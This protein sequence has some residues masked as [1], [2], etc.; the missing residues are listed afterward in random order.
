MADA[1][2]ANTPDWR[3]ADIGTANGHGNA[4][5][6]ARVMSVLVG[7]ERSSG[8]GTAIFGAVRG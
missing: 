1:A 5:S 3:R 2:A 7:S 8:Y 4:R 6:V